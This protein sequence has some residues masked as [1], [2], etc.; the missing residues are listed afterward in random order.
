MTISL[1]IHTENQIKLKSL[2]DLIDR[3][4]NKKDFNINLH[5]KGYVPWED[6]QL[7]NRI[8]SFKSYFAFPTTKEKTESIVELISKVKDER[9]ILIDEDCQSLPIKLWEANYLSLYFRKQDLKYLNLDTKYKSIEWLIIDL[10]SQKQKEIIGFIDDSEDCSRYIRK[11]ESPLFYE[12]II[13]IDG[14]MGDHIMALPLIEKLSS[15]VYVSCKYPFVYNHI[16]LKGMID[17][18]DELFGGYKIFVYEFGSR[19]NSKTII[20]AFFEMYDFE[21]ESSDILIYKGLREDN[22]DVPLN[23]K[24]ALICTSA[25]KIQNQDSNKDWKDIRWFKLVHELKKQDYYVI[26]VGSKNDN[27]IPNVDLKFLDRPLGNLA[28]LVDDSSLWL[29]VDTFFHHFASAVK[30]EVG[31]CLTP[32]YNDHAKHNG[33]RYIEKDCG[34]NYFD[35]K[36]WLDLQ[37]PERKECMYL[38]QIDDVLSTM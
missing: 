35:R 27:Q 20:D 16:P 22:P 6:E 32:F 23:R 7:K 10:I 2:L 38:I 19:N 21:R 29:S 1:I 11:T 15:Q 36:W 30:P 4:P 25:A 3:H 33:V 5:A 31:I 37:Q 26:Q 8:I 34:K 13:Y 17:W 28:K 18:N 12:K 24:L 9:M 14:G